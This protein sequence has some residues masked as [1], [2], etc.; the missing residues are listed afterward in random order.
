MKWSFILFFVSTL[1]YKNFACSCAPQVLDFCQTQPFRSSTLV[2]LAKVVSFGDDMLN[3]WGSPYMNIVPLEFLHHTDARDTFK[4]YGQ[5]GLN[6]NVYLSNFSLGDTV[7]LSLYDY[8]E[9]FNSRYDLIACGVYFLEYHNDSVSGN[10]TSG[11]SSMSF[12][13]FKTFI[14]ACIAL[15]VE[16]KN[17]PDFI[18]LFPVPAQTQLNFKLPASVK[19]YSISIFDLAG[20]KISAIVNQNSI[21][22]AHFPAGIYSAI[23]ETDSGIR[24]TKKFLKE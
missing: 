2:V 16:E 18:N 12:A 4:V 1:T 21:S 13:D 8:T 20:K 5:D 14:P 11:S 10:I 3:P 15:D 24:Y 17:N 7:L 9:T 23:I 22:V 6:C 19:S